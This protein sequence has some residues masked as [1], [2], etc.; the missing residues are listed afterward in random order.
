M[1]GQVPN[2]IANWLSERKQ[3]VADEGWGESALWRLASGV[4]GAFWVSW[5][6]AVIGGGSRFLRGK[7][8][9]FWA[10]S[11]W[12]FWRFA[13]LCRL[14][15][16]FFFPWAFWLH[17]GCGARAMLALRSLGRGNTPCPFLERGS[18]L[19]RWKPRQSLCSA[20]MHVRKA[21]GGRS[22][23]GCCFVVGY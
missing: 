16:I 22:E 20:R 1:A 10:E 5:W 4:G 11:L 9:P 7:T 18:D 2:W 13:L 14:V 6:P 15:E 8:R 3:R 12:R 17:I 23:G 19:R 21:D